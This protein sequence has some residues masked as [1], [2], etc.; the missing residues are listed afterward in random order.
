MSYSIIRF[1]SDNREREVKQTGL[2]LK[3]AQ[4]H[5]QDPETSSETTTTDDEPGVWFDGYREV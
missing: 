4:A 2:T 5:C 1:Y 3:E